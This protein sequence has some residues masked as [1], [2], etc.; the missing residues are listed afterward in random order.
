MNAL[1]KISAWLDDA[2]IT[3]LCINADGQ[4]WIDRG[5]GLEPQ[6]S[7]EGARRELA[8]GLK[9]WV[10]EQLSRAGRSWD[11]RNPFVDSPLPPA[12]RLHAVFPPVGGEGVSVSLRRL[13]RTLGGPA[14]ARWASSGRFY[15]PLRQAVASGQSVL[16]A[17]STGSGKTTLLNDLLASV[18][19]RERLVALEDTPELAPAHPHFVA[20]QSRAANADGFGEVTIRALLRQALRMRP[21]RILVGECR[22]G[23]VLDLLQALNTGHEG[24]LATIHANS[25]RDALRRLEILALLSAPES[26]SIAALREWIAAGIRWV[27]HV[28]RGADGQ[29]RI[30]ELVR[31]QGIESGT[32]LLRPWEAGGA[33]PG[34]VL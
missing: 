34:D 31:V 3:D 9:G 15:E 29:R 21:D 12:H 20:L 5:T 13:G 10:L 1:E 23:E 19:A 8:A 11:A 17:G 18:P 24:S 14:E 27:A 4:A 6:L 26:L 7:D 32:I 33:R 2:A 30:H 22:G 25:A 28:R 16:I